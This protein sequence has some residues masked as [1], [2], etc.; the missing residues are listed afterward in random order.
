MEDQVQR[1]N[2]DELAFLEDCSD[3]H[4]GLESD[5]TSEAGSPIM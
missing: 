2:R 3:E 1:F 5:L 4:P